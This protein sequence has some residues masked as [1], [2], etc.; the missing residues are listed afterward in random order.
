MA[1]SSFMVLLS[2]LLFFLLCLLLSSSFVLL[3][4]NV[5]KRFVYTF[6]T[7]MFVKYDILTEY[8][9]LFWFAMLVKEYKP[10][11]QFRNKLKNMKFRQCLCQQLSFYFSLF[12]TEAMSKQAS[13]LQAACCRSQT[14]RSCVDLQLPRSEG[15]PY[16]N[17]TSAM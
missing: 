17:T 13:N 1:R 11:F 2:T 4:L 10:E 8:L 16:S 14:Y 6:S 5:N 9:T 12:W 7:T 3:V 15:R